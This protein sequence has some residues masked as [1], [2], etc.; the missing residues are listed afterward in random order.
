MLDLSAVEIV[1]HPSKTRP[2]RTD[3]VGV[4]ELHYGLQVDT[5]ELK[6]L[7]EAEVKKII[8]FKIHS[9]AYSELLSPMAE[10]RA[11]VLTN[12]SQD[13]RAVELCNQ[14][15]ELLQPKI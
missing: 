1:D 15:Q 5:K 10:L 6:T 12:L 7:G 9:M 4:L 8:Q 14:I 11:H 3:F 13:S 2:D